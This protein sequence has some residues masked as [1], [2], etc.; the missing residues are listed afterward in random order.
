MKKLL[1]ILLSLVMLLTLTTTAFA[2][3][4]EYGVDKGSITINKYDEENIYS[5]YRMLDLQSFDT[6]GTGTYSYTI[7]AGWEDFFGV[8]GDGAAYVT[9]DDGYVTWKTGLSDSF[10]PEFAKKA[11]AYA[12]AEGLAALENSG[13]APATGSVLVDGISWPTYKFENL[14]L[15][16]Y[17]VDSTMGALCGLTTTNPHASINAKN[18]EPTLKKEGSTATADIGQV[19]DYKIT[20]TVA[21]GAQGFILHDDMSAGLTLDPSSIAVSYDGNP[22]DSINYTVKTSGFSDTCDFEVEFTPAFCDTLSAGKD[23]V[24]SYSATLNENAVIAGEGN[25]NTATLE[26]GEDHFTTP[27][28]VTTYTYAFDLVKTDAQNSLLPGAKFEMYLTQTGGDAVQLFY[29]SVGKYYRPFV[30]GDVGSPVTEF[31]VTDGMIRFQGFDPG[32][33]Y[34]EETEAPA[35][36]NK[37][38]ARAKFTLPAGNKD[39]IFNDGIYSSGSGFHIINQSG[40]MLPETGALGTVLFTVLGSG[41]ALGTGV[42][43]VTKKRMSKIKDED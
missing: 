39:A 27:S 32:D 29:D 20:V 42:V 15:G 23:L 34:F 18:G 4:G 22:V 36:Y 25:S 35:G 9:I 7:S 21:A 30:T 16:Y 33:Y 28:K 6:T 38:T 40:T 43:L 10:A 37:L 31:E 8:G 41:T 2:V 26:F 14:E 1:T 19:I 11:L 12:K 13:N 5:L 3:T 24:V 17:L